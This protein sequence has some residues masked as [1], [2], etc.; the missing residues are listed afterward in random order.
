MLRIAASAM[1]ALLV[2]GAAVAQTPS[3]VCPV[4]SAAQK[5]TREFIENYQS[6]TAALQSQAYDVALSKA[7]SAMRHAWNAQQMQAALAVQT[8]AYSA[9]HDD[10]NLANVIETR[11]A[12]GC[13]SEAEEEKLKAMQPGLQ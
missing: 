10:A 2:G 3:A 5:A 8:A 6:A 4:K 12:L 7:A 9:Q 1:V 11:L 13:M